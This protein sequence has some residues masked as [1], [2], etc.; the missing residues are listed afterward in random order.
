[1]EIWYNPACSKCRVAKELLDEA[2]MSYEL[3]R[4]LDDPPTAEE[5]ERVLDAL[6]LQPWEIARTGDALAG[7]VGLTDLPR[8]R[9]PWVQALVEHPA[10]IQRPILVTADGT[11]Y[12]GRSAEAVREAIAHEQ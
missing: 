6:D 8:E 5:L 12:V 10:L 11:A 3:R 7:Q 9:G 4:Y 2:G 1:M